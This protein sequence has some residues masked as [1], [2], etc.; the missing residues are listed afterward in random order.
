[1]ELSSSNIKNS[2]FSGNKTL[3]FLTSTLKTFLEEI[4][5]IFP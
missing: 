3:Q 4:S 5:Y 2:Y 1:M